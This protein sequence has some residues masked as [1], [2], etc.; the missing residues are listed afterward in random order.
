MKEL[1]TGTLRSIFIFDPCRTAVLLIGGDKRGHKRFYSQV[2]ALA[3]Q[4][5]EI[6]LDGLKER[7]E[8]DDAEGLGRGS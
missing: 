8:A 4:L 5:Y 7:I 1:R 3:D 2:I 6:Y